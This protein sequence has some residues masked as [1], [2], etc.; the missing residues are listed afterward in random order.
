MASPTCAVVVV[1]DAEEEGSVTLTLSP[2]MGLGST[3]AMGTDTDDTDMECGCEWMCD[4][5]WWAAF[6]MGLAVTGTVVDGEVDDVDD[7][8][9][10]AAAAAG[11]W[12]GIM[13][14][15]EGAAAL[16]VVVVVVEGEGLDE[17]KNGK[18]VGTPMFVACG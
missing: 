9:A 18:G 10:A 8:D 13:E 16:V 4:D 5:A 1:P 7:A 17:A 15:V 6:I 11:C 3:P 12:V 2:T 14:V